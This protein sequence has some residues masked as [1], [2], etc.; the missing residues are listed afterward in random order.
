LFLHQY[1]VEFDATAC[2]VYQLLYWSIN[3]ASSFAHHEVL[4]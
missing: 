3:R 4:D 1:F 2:E